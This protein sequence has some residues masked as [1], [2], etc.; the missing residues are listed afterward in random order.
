[1]QPV[2]YFF[3][4]FIC[5]TAL[6]FAGI[7]AASAKQDCRDGILFDDVTGKPVVD[8]NTGKTI[9]CGGQVE[10][11]TGISTT[12][13][14]LGGAVAAGAGVGIAAAAGAFKGSTTQQ[15]GAPVPL[16]GQ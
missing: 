5:A 16:S 12:A 4:A 2:R 13:I 15:F 6:I 8:Q 7:S 9:R 14:L 11:D 1:M 10:G 3:R